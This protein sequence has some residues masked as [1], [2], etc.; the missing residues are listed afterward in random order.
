MPIMPSGFVPL[1][2]AYSGGDPGGVI[3][4]EV[5]GGPGRYRTDW[6]RGRQK[7]SVTITLDKSGLSVWLLFF[8]HVIKKGA[9]AFDM[10]LDSG[11]GVAPHA[12]R[13][14][15]GSY[16]VAALS[17]AYTVAFAVECESAVYALS[18]TQVAAY[19]LSAAAMPSGLVPMVAGYSFDGPGGVLRD[20]VAGGNAGYGLEFARG[21]QQF[22]CT[23]MLTAA[24]F[25]IWSVWYHR[26][27]HKG[28][29]TF[30]MR[31]DSGFGPELHSATIIPGSYSFA[32]TGGNLTVVSFA[33]EAESK[34]Y[35]FSAADA[36]FIVELHSQS[37][38]AAG[39]LLARLAQFATIDTLVLDF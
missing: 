38:G 8:H 13:M 30:D 21:T 23:L 28:G 3:R 17:G 1:V 7:F 4:T 26:L 14:I 39:A 18:D 29:Q 32:R 16:S 11:L 34:A 25:A 10:R 2:A 9:L 5:A 35:D 33:V 20:E 27:I 37:G 15:P 19:G 22:S 36:A 24:K 6:A 12:V 31:L